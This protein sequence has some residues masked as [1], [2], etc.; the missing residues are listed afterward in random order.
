MPTFVQ[1]K[2]V[3]V[4]DAFAKAMQQNSALNMAHAEYYG[5]TIAKQ[6]EEIN[7]VRL[8]NAAKEYIATHND[9]HDPG[10]QR[11][12]TVAGMAK[13]FFST[14]LGVT[15]LDNPVMSEKTGR[16]QIADGQGVGN[17]GV[18]LVYT[19]GQENSRNAA[20]NATSVANNKNTQEN[21]NRRNAATITGH[22]G[23]V[24]REIAGRQAN[25]EYTVQ[26]QPV[27]VQIPQ[28]PGAPP[29]F[30][31]VDKATA[32]T[33]GGGY[34]PILEP[35]QAI[36]GAFAQGLTNPPPPVAA[37]PGPGGPQPTAP[38]GVLSGGD[39]PDAIPSYP[40]AAAPGMPA[41]TGPPVQAP[42][43][44]GRD[45]TAT[46]TITPV[47]SGPPGVVQPS[48]VPPTSMTGGA[49]P[50][51]A[52]P[53]GIP[54]PSSVAPPQAAVP[55]YN[56]AFAGI[57]TM[58][59]GMPP[60][61]RKVA[62]MEPA[63]ARP[64]MNPLTHEYGTSNDQGQS[65]TVNGVRKPAQGFVPVDP[66]TAMADARTE[67]SKSLLK[68]FEI[69]DPTASAAFKAA[70]TGGVGGV[71]GFARRDLDAFI[72]ATG[73]SDIVPGG[74]AS[75]TAEAA[76]QKVG[77]L[78]NGLLRGL[79][80]DR[81]AEAGDRERSKI[82]SLLPDP[83]GIL[84]NPAVEAQKFVTI[85]QMLMERNNTLNARARDPAMTGIEYNK[86]QNELA[87]NVEALHMVTEPNWGQRYMPASTDTEVPA[88]N[89][90]APTPGVDVNQRPGGPAPVGPKYSATATGKDGSRV[91]FNPQTNAWEPLSGQ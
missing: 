80:G 13:N 29:K 35:K 78:R 32:T 50:P 77:V 24:D 23:D 85:Y 33:P 61:V 63:V 14:N 84:A 75:P 58:L 51:A 67:A 42:A 2:P 62:D 83:A 18:G 87:A 22:S 19:Q 39:V 53:Q 72:G 20:T 28:A 69:A 49:P 7:A 73:L 70:T 16:A 74:Q 30:A 46:K 17:T 47:V 76:A 8:L 68:P 44:N 10:L 90:G 11:A 79:L 15:A 27:N 12:L 54:V 38:G 43:P 86:L 88:A 5:S 81:G 60:D 26:H 57:D 66:N 6:Q 40:G 71:A 4:S 45:L 3:P 52:P 89:P 59:Q 9:P 31:I 37:P 41:F 48:V 82:A 36:G 56:P 34:M 65:V 64:M 1:A 25:T 91:G 21:E 55:A